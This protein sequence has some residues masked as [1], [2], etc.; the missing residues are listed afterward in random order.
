MG[1]GQLQEVFKSF[2]SIL[3]NDIFLQPPAEAATRFTKLNGILTFWYGCVK[4]SVIGT[5]ESQPLCVLGL[6]WL[7][8][9]GL[10]FILSDNR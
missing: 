8:I 9:W 4:L 7:R 6:R 3:I 2:F 10:F 1:P 5:G